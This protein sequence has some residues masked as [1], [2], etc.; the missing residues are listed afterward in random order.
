MFN[1]YFKYVRIKY[2]KKKGGGKEIGEIIIGK[3]N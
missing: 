2:V 1:V 3:V